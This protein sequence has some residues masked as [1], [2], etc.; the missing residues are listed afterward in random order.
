[1]NY[2]NT[3][4]YKAL[5]SYLHDRGHYKNIT[6]FT[7]ENKEELLGQFVVTTP[8]SERKECGERCFCGKK[9]LNCYYVYC[10]KT[11]ELLIT[12]NS[13]KKIFNEQKKS[14]KLLNKKIINIF[15]NGLGFSTILNWDNYVE[16]VLMC[17]LSKRSVEELSRFKQVY[18]NEPKSLEFVT[19]SLLDRKEREREEE[20]EKR[21]NRRK[22]REAKEREK[23]ERE[24]EEERER[25]L[26]RRRGEREELG[27]KR[28]EW[29]KKLQKQAI[30]NMLISLLMKR[31][32]EREE[33]EESKEREEYLKTL[34]E[35][36]DDIRSCWNYK[37][38]QIKK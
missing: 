3:P 12:G 35:D 31:I 22:K 7:S 24:E 18:S 37:N 30:R 28:E 13:C 4:K 1:M 2:L 25:W 17:W 15:S 20:R 10:I 23:I 36:Y 38:T 16:D 34:G 6:K 26:A 14:K 32:E 33:D 9:I 19:K 8:V 21:I 27:R 11:D 5:I 29:E